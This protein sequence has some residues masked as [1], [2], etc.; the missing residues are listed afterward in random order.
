M[1]ELPN[2]Q[3][4]ALSLLSL[5]TPLARFSSPHHLPELRFL[6]SGICGQ[7]LFSGPHPVFTPSLSGLAWVN[8]LRHM[9]TSMN[10]TRD[11]INGVN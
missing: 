8:G 3:L 4:Y 11:E 6:P 5:E 10:E 2:R 1:V 7:N 9:L